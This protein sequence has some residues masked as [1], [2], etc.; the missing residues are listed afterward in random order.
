[1][2]ADSKRRGELTRLGGEVGRE[3]GRFGPQAGLA[4]LV[5]RWPAAVGPEIARFAWPARIGRDGTVHVHTADSTWAFELAHRASD[6]A[7]RVGV[8]RLRFS[9]GPLPAADREE[10][11]REPVEPGPAHEA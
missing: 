2:R 10:D 7:G 9:P 5:N 8:K 6:I 11:V 3:L 4:E 1:M